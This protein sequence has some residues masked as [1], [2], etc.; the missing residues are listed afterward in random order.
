MI[1]RTRLNIMPRIYMN[2]S[3]VW[4]YLGERR[5]S[6]G[7]GPAVG[8]VTIHN[9]DRLPLLDRRDI[10][11]HYTARFDV[12]IPPG[13][14]GRFTVAP[15]V[16][17]ASR[18][19]PAA[20]WASVALPELSMF[21]CPLGDDALRHFREQRGMHLLDLCGTLVTDA[22]GPVL[23]GLVGLEWLSLTGT[24]IGTA[25]VEHLGGLPNLLRLS[26]R[27]TM[28]TDNALVAVARIPHLLWLSVA[29]TA[30][31]SYGIEALLA[32]APRL[33]TVVIART[34]AAAEARTRTLPRRPGVE[35]VLE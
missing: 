8:S 29:D 6:F 9:R 30:I 21:E 11:A 28:I 3:G 1:P 15:T 33:R 18:L 17:D 4:P 34:P 24:G 19:A 14:S 22:S 5:L 16:D 32:R 10:Y 35:L 2:R 12:L 25:G 23:A 26:L 27:A 13:L 7:D 31:T 20:L